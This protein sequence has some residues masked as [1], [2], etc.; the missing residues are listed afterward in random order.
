MI[1]SKAEL[2]VREKN[3]MNNQKLQIIYGGYSAEQGLDLT[4]LGESFIGLNMVLKEY[5]EISRFNG[6]VSI[7]TEKVSDGSIIVEIIFIILS[8][9]M[10]FNEIR[11]LLDFLR[12]VNEAE[13]KVASAFFNKIDNTSKTI[14]DYYKEY[15]FHAALMTIALER[16][17]VKLWKATPFYKK[18][19][20]PNPQE[21][22][23]KRYAKKIYEMIH[24]RR[25][26]RAL[27]P[28]M[29]EQVSYIKM[30][31][32]EYEATADHGNFEDYL[33]EDEKILP[34]L[35]NGTVHN[36][37]GEI[38]AL[39]ST[40]GE[41]LKVRIHDFEPKYNLLVAYPEEDK[42]TEDYKNYYK[43]TANMTVEILRKSLYKKPE[44]K[45]IK[46]EIV[47]ENLV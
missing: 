5:L 2:I 35:Q 20:V 43:K 42:K 37:I 11:D 28:L 44:F 24:S 38:V 25:Y 3:V 9:E 7:R 26:K 27:K 36:F 15:P 18:S 47:Q 4:V 12:V 33:A 41:T 39:Q 45:L 40:R 23:P 21:K 29:E 22:L 19:P 32:S 17:A 10:P 1:I 16:L 13:Y 31:V 8:S 46:I 6:E 34:D 30:R 14:N